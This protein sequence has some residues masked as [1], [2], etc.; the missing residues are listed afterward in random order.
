MTM[1]PDQT[2]G[3]GPG[4]Q[5]EQPQVPPIGWQQGGMPPYGG[6][7]PYGQ[8]PCGQY[9]Q[10]PYGQAPYG[11]YGQAPYQP[12]VTPPTF[13]VSE[14][15]SFGAKL[16]RKEFIWVP[17]AISIASALIPALIRLL[18]STAQSPALAGLTIAAG[19]FAAAISLL[20]SAIVFRALTDITQGRTPAGSIESR[21]VSLAL[22]LLGASILL[23]LA[24]IVPY[25]VVGA[26]VILLFAVFWPLAILGAIVAAVAWSYIYLRLALAPALIAEGFGI[27]NAYRESWRLSRGSVLRI[28]GW[29]L[30]TGLVFGL[31]PLFLT[32]LLTLAVPIAGAVVGAAVSVLYIVMENAV[33]VMLVHACRW[34][35]ATLQSPFAPTSGYGQGAGSPSTPAAPGASSWPTYEAPNFD[36]P[37]PPSQEPPTGQS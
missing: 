32:L 27:V 37:T 16:L 33:T 24:T 20:P 3:Q 34:R 9:G 18:G 26:L 13:S 10:S 25:I 4:P 21:D 35:L 31:L 30:A 8:Q 6:Q 36:A 29:G 5:P 14:A 12:P 7:A 1:P 2:P 19:L 22:R 17:L 15:W 23:G 11:Q 28:F